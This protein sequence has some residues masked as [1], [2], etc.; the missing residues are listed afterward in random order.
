MRIPVQSP[1][2]CRAA[3]TRPAAYD[4]RG[5]HPSAAALLMNMPAFTAECSLYKSTRGYGGALDRAA[6]RGAVVPAQQPMGT[7]PTVYEPTPT[8]GVVFL[9]VLFCHFDQGTIFGK[10]FACSRCASFERKTVC[11]DPTKPSTCK[12][13]WTQVTPWR[14]NCFGEFGVLS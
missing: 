9:P 4:G 14:T 3:M 6:V 12:T 13:E 2:A 7:P 8:P 10:T 11:T 5:V 1:G